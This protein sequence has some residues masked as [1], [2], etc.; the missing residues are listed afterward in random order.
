MIMLEHLKCMDMGMVLST[1]YI[2]KTVT[3]EA[4]AVLAMEQGVG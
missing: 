4:I 2:C 3:V 1:V